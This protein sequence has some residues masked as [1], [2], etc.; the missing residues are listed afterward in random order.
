MKKFIPSKENSEKLVIS[1][2]IDSKLLEKI[3][4]EAAKAEISRNEMIN[5]SSHYALS[6]LEENKEEN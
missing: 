4:E 2:R 1:I 3:D 5:Q 6:N